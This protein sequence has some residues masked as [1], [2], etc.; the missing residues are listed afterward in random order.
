M[1]ESKET[2]DDILLNDPEMVEAFVAEAGV[3]IL[4]PGNVIQHPCKEKGL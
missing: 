4:N 1:S 2:L 3:A